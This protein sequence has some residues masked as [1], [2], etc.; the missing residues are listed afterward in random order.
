MAWFTSKVSVKFVDDASGEIFATTEIP[1]NDLPESFE[2]D[3][4]LHLSDADWTVVDAQ[5]R[6]RAE[7]A[8][9]KTLVLRIRR[10]ELVDPSTILFSL[11]SICD[12]IPGV[13]DSALSGDEFVLAEDD[14]R[15]FEFVSNKLRSVVD[16]EIKQI[17]LIHEN[18]S[19]EVGWRKIH[20]RSNPEFPIACDLK[21]ADLANTLNANKSPIGLSYRGAQSQIADGYV[22]HVDGITVY[23]VA[24]NG[25]VQT[26]AFDQ[27]SDDS[28]GPNSIGRL[29]S[30]AQ[31]LEFDLV[32]WCRCIRATPDDPVFETLFINGAT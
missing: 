31:N 4:T 14:W 24:P 16:N 18:E 11:P 3:T 30:I 13:S 12:V 26:I 9:S 10:V 27:Y 7:Y 2:L 19:A 22:F 17:R 29:K 20:V 15:Q 25:H 1:P 23:G 5:P 28:P 6:T 21:L 8:K 32:Y